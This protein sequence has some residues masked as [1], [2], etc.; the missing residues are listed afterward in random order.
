MGGGAFF[1][2]KKPPGNKGQRQG[3]RHYQGLGYLVLLIKTGKAF[4]HHA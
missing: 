4:Y 3:G 1:Q 2:H